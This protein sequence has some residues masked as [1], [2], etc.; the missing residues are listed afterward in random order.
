EILQLGV[1]TSKNLDVDCEVAGNFV[2]HTRG[3]ELGRGAITCIA[4]RTDGSRGQM[5]EEAA[6]R[7][8]LVGEKGSIEERGLE[9]RY[10]EAAEQASQRFGDRGIAKDIVE[11]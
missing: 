5:V 11:E 10:L 3:N 4:G 9:Y 1:G 6:R 8:F 7:V 2:D